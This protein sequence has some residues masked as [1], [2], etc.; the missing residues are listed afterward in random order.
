M[1]VHRT[2]EPRY[3]PDRHAGFTP[4]APSWVPVLTKNNPPLHRPLDL[5]DR[6]TGLPHLSGTSAAAFCGSGVAHTIRVR[7]HLPDAAAPTLSPARSEASRALSLQTPQE[8]ACSSPGH[9]GPCR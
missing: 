5:L 6:W 2:M 3:R 7:L 9:R 1:R 4:G 8:R